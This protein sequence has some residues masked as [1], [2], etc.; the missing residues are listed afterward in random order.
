MAHSLEVRTP[1]IDIELF[2]AATTLAHAGTPPSKMDMAIS[3]NKQLPL[4][5]L[6]R[7]KSGFSI[8]VDKWLGN[9]LKR[10][11]NRLLEY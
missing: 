8:P 11:S 7:P 4:S 3:P 6:N 2:K 5:I 10:W 1:L 9:N